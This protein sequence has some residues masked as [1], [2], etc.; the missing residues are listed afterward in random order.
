MDHRTGDFRTRSDPYVPSEERV[1]SDFV[2]EYNELQEQRNTGR[3]INIHSLFK[4][5]HSYPPAV[6]SAVPVLKLLFQKE[7]EGKIMWHPQSCVLDACLDGRGPLSW[8]VV[9][10]GE[11]VGDDAGTHAGAGQ[12]DGC[13]GGGGDNRKHHTLVPVR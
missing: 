12:C 3:C 9:P 11:D 2:A 6:R 13:G 8:C 1:I 4:R 5:L 10:G 7:Q